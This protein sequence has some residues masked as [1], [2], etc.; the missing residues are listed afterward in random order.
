[1][2]VVLVLSYQWGL[3]EVCRVDGPKEITFLPSPSFQVSS[4]SSLLC[5]YVYGLPSL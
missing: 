3:P 4:P 2:N 1:M 5:I